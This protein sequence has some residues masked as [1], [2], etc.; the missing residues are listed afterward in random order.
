MPHDRDAQK[1]TLLEITQIPTASGSEERVIGYIRRWAAERSDVSVQSDA[2]GNLLLSSSLLSR[3]KASGSQRGSTAGRV[4][5]P[6][7][8]LITAHLDHPAFVV[9]RT[10]GPHACELSFRGG[11]MEPYFE[12]ARIVIHTDDPNAAPI[13]ATLTGESTDSPANPFGKLYMAELD[14][15]EPAGDDDDPLSRI[16]PG[17]VGVWALPPAQ[18]DE[19]NILRAPA[20]DDLSA[21]AAALEAFEALR[22]IAKDPG[23]KRGNRPGPIDTRL[24]LTRAEEIGFIGAIAACKLGTIP[25]GSR[26]V[27]LENSRAFADSPIGAGPIVRVGDRMSVF[28]PRLTAACAKRAEDLAGRATTPPTT[29]RA[30][31]AKGIKWQRKL[32]AGGACE[33]TVFCAY[34]HEATCLCLPLGNYH[35][36]TDLDTVQ[37]GKHDA[38]KD[39]PPR[40]GREFISVDDY[41]GLID[42]LIALGQGLPEV[43]PIVPR[44]EAL[45]AGK[46]AVLREGRDA[47]GKNAA[48]APRKPQRRAAA[49]KARPAK[50]GPRSNGKPKKPTS[51]AR[52]RT[53]KRTHGR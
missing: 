14:D 28:S 17:D 39:G 29:E 20:C 46:S 15:S 30:D 47:A 31:T 24:L 3:G 2:A 4:G 49:K 22:K 27:A 23:T 9:E 38:A 48:A 50:T 37:A 34:G 25:K 40:I 16:K 35:N 19:E 26:V 33:A 44:L 53:R 11:V 42:L 45:Y 13:G 43:D 5:T 21:V 41:F 32:M 10:I 8:L 18:I 7:P 52:P 12:S 1:R 36:M 6:S 51:K